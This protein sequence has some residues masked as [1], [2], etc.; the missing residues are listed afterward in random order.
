MLITA[1]YRSSTLVSSWNRLWCETCDFSHGPSTN[2]TS[3]VTY[4]YVTSYQ[5]IVGVVL[6]STCYKCGI[7]IHW[8]DGLWLKWWSFLN[9]LNRWS[10]SIFELVGTKLMLVFG[11]WIWKP[12]NG[13]I[14]VDASVL[15][16]LYHGVAN[17][18]G[19]RAITT[20]L[21]DWACSWLLLW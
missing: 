6:S 8:L 4:G 2:P 10:Y 13:A 9:L 3:Q 7:E 18:H 5:T 12:K 17:C 15:G 20:S 21:N 11:G 1:G 19:C 14:S 16:K